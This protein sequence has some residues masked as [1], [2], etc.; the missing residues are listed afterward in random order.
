M[1]LIIVAFIANVKPKVGEATEDKDD[2]VDG[3]SEDVG[4]GATDNTINYTVKNTDGAGANEGF[5]EGEMVTLG[6]NGMNEIFST[7]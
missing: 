4:F 7:I 3:S 1:Y 2:T 5:P 6:A